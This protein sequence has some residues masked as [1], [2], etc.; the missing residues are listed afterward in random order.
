MYEFKSLGNIEQLQEMPENANVIVEVD[1]A[2]RRAPK[3]DGIGKLVE[4]EMLEEV[5]EGA[6]VLAEVN[7]KIKR[8]PGEG[9]GGGKSIVF[10]VVENTSAVATYG[11]GAPPLYKTVCNC[12]INEVRELIMAGAPVVQIIPYEA[13]M[14][15]NMPSALDASGPTPVIC[16][17]N[18]ITSML[19]DDGSWQFMFM[20][21]GATFMIYYFADG[22]IQNMPF[23]DIY[24]EEN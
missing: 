10:T 3:E 14:R 23:D 18:G 9:L 22:T 12:T 8:V 17:I 19:A 15:L 24:Q 13:L 7:G 20:V 5:P 1:G 2:V 21:E 16:T 11:A 6:T 4:T